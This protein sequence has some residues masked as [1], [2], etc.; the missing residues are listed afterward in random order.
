MKR[1]SSLAILTA[2]LSPGFHPAPVSGNN[3]TP[4]ETAAELIQK[5]VAAGVL[6]SAV[7]RVRR[8]G[9]T[10]ERA[11]GKAAS[12]E[13]VFLLASISKTLTAAG[14]MVLIDRGE[15]RLEAPVKTYLPEFSEGGRKDVTLE[16]LL[17]HTSGLP[18]QLPENN[19]LRRRHAPMDDFVKGALRTPLLFPPGTRYHYQS[20]GLLLA[21]EVARRVTGLPL[22]DFLARE[23]F[24]VLGMRNTTMGLGALRPEETVRCQTEHAAPEAGGGDVTARDWDWNSAYWRSLG[25]PWGGAHGTATDIDRFLGSFLHPE[26]KLMRIESARMMTENHTPGLGARRGLG[27]AL[28]PEGFGRECSARTFGHG[29]ST[30]TL[31][32]A[33][34]E[35]DLT[36][37]ILTSLPSQVSGP[38]ILHPVSDL[39]AAAH[40]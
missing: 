14:V 17:T 1:R 16:H 29:G 21:G 3:A 22:A 7:L 4:M 24:P 28:G 25:A 15:L 37:V 27:F 38:L 33:D 35:K 5:Q 39:V 32:W 40:P 23:V 26:G 2:G 10:F 18:D 8:G 12:G 6:E 30:G 36:C 20:M 34:P 31:A 11:F 9:E 19:E 13:A